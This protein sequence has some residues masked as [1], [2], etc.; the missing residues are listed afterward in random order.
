MSIFDY[1]FKDDN[2]N[3]TYHYSKYNLDKDQKNDLKETTR[4][5]RYTVNDYGEFV[6][7]KSND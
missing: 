2:K 1:L 3:D 6:E 5:S 4:D 7:I